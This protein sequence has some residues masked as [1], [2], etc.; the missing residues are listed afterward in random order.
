[1][2]PEQR[3]SIHF[4]F[5]WTAAGHWEGRDFEV[6]VDVGAK[7]GPTSTRPNREAKDNDEGEPET[8]PPVGAAH[9][10]SV[11]HV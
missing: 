4:T 7:G 5:Y 9:E 10:E 1:M 8:P 3:A 11:A 2:P 6:G